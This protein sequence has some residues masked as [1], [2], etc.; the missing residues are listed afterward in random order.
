M[1]LSGTWR[2]AGFDRERRSIAL[3][4]GQGGCEGIEPGEELIWIG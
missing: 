3:E 2:I 4:A 1:T